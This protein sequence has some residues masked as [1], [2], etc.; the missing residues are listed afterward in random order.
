MP[1]VA[2]LGG[3][4]GFEVA[5]WTGLLAPKGTAKVLVEQIN[6]DVARAVAE[7][8]VRER[9]GGFGYEAWPL[10]PAATTAA[11]EA[12]VRRYA[13]TVSRLNLKLD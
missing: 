2:E 5:A 6:R 10:S 8:D 3:P 4:A 1:T 9:F 11:I 7:P 12:E 13:N